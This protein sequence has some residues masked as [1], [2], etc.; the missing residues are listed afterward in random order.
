MQ[1]TSERSVFFFF[2]NG[3]ISTILLSL[4]VSILKRNHFAAVRESMRDSVLFLLS[5]Y[6][7][8]NRTVCFGSFERKYKNRSCEGTHKSIRS[9]HL[10][11]KLSMRACQHTNEKQCENYSTTNI[12]HLFFYILYL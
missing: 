6:T 5:A 1:K 10:K 2:S 9:D 11:H 3:I 12:I 7:Y 8:R 4:C